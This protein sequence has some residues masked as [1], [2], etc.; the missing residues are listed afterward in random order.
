MNFNSI[1]NSL[2]SSIKISKINSLGFLIRTNY[3]GNPVENF[4]DYDN[5]LAEFKL[6]N[7]FISKAT[8]F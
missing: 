3:N 4:I 7:Y 5:F 2:F 1:S 6:D 8:K